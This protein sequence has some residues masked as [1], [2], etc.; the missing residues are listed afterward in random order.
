MFLTQKSS[1]VL[2]I[3]TTEHTQ[4]TKVW[5][6]TPRPHYAPPRT[7]LALRVG[8]RRIYAAALRQL[9]DSAKFAS[10][11]IIGVKISAKTYIW[12]RMRAQRAFPT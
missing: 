4:F 7:W 6:S 11:P 12:H 10:K 8:N 1:T 9:L 2:P 5:E 3:T